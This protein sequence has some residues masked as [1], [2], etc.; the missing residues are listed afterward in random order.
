MR[1]E[2]GRSRAGALGG[3]KEL[4]GDIRE[5]KRTLM[6][7]HLLGSASAERRSLVAFLARE[8]STPMFQTTVRRISTPKRSSS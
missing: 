6:L 8:E 5:G 7:I 1:R 4:L 2:D 3:R